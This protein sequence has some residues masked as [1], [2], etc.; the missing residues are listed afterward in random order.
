MGWLKK[1]L[2]PLKGGKKG[3]LNMLDPG[4]LTRK[5][6]KLTPQKLLGGKR[7]PNSMQNPYDSEMPSAA[8]MQE[9]QKPPVNLGPRAKP[10]Y[11]TPPLQADDTMYGT[12]PV[13]KPY[14]IEREESTDVMSTTADP[15]EEYFAANAVRMKPMVSDMYSMRKNREQDKFYQRPRTNVR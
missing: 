4:G 14:G 10:A 11:Q 6:M 7:D 2:N 8:G 13:A 15:K 1:M 12:K 3:V 5:G 9:M